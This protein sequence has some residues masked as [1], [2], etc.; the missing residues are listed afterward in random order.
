M[1]CST[2]DRLVTLIGAGGSG[3]TRLAVEVA[4]DRADR[5]PRRA[6]FVDL[7]PLSDLD[8]IAEAI[9]AAVGAHEQAGEDT[10]RDRGRLDR[11]RRAPARGRQLRARRWRGVAPL[12]ERLLRGLSEPR[13]AGHQ[14]G[15]ARH[16]RRARPACFPRSRLPPEPAEAST[17]A[18]YDAVRLFLD[19]ARARASTTSTS[20]PGEDAAV[21]ELVRRLDGMPL[22]IELAAARVPV[23]T[24]AQILRG[25]DDRFRLL[26]RSDGID[27]AATGRWSPPSTGATTCSTSRSRPCCVGSP[28][29]RAASR[30]TRPSRS[31]PA[32]RSS[33]PTCSTSSPVWSPSR[34]SW[35]TGPRFE[36]ARY[37]L[38][39]TMRAYGRC[40]WSRPARITI[41]HVRHLEWAACA[42]GHGR[43]GAGRS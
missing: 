8:R 14:P 32:E 27:D 24:T 2:H 21:G 6:R 19:R 28:C 16:R 11:R 35:S 33:G 4:R 10:G 40:G 13:R 17:M 20:G 39:E 1:P 25:I 38:L 22:A 7:T 9:R 15:A 37:R 26:A 30:S 43:A 34:W 3:K 23:M 5:C 42:R 41:S 36:A 29:S 12:V 31:P 18:S